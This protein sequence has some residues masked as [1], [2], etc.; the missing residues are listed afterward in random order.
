MEKPIYGKLIDGIFQ[1]APTRV[2]WHGKTVI[3]PRPEKLIELG[4][5]LLVTIGTP[6]YDDIDENQ[7]WTYDYTEDDKNIYRTWVLKTYDEEM[8]I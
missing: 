8:I 7:Y 2:K 6:N 5:K 1:K 3:N 4:Y